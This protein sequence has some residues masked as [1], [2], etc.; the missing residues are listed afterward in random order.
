MDPQVVKQ[1]AAASLAEASY[2]P[3]KLAFLHT[4]VVV[5][6]SLVTTL[7]SF[8]L[9]WAAGSAVG[10]S[11][12]AL[13]SVLETAQMILSLASS[14]VLPFWQIGFIYAAMRYNRRESV[15]TG[16]LLEGFRRLGPVFRL[17][18]LL[19]LF[20]MGVLFACFYIA[21]T[22]FTFSPLSDG[23]YEALTRLFETAGADIV[24]PE[25]VVTLLPHM[26]GLFVLTGLILLVI[27]LPFYYRY[28][29]SEFALMNG[30]KGA[31]AAMRESVWIT[32]NRRM[33]LFRFDLSFWWF[34]AAQLLI[35]AIAFGGQILSLCGISL[36]VNSDGL[37]W[38]LF[39]LQAAAML[40]F[41]RQYGAYYQTAYARYYDLLREVAIPTPQ[42]ES[43]RE[44]P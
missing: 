24:T 26:V 12:I 33:A 8:L 15:S 4:G 7:L 39:A 9:D 30:A 6:F 2:D 35:S 27:G 34:Y 41:T 38:I 14:V 1:H 25:M 13:R 5:L 19:L 22:I 31:L 32:R 18:V 36:P 10:L 28:R 23:F 29:M 17:N 37:Y 40:V 21:T 11:G 42:Q 44:L 16:S 20:V 43:K 3:K